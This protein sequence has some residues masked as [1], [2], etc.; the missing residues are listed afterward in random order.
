MISE[1]TREEIDMWLY[2]S[3]AH[4]DNWHTQEWA[5]A[6]LRKVAIE[7]GLEIGAAQ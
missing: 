1:D 7:N 2:Y 3:E 6:L 4:P 5:I